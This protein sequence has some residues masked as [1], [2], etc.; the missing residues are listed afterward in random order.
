MLAWLVMTSH[1]ATFL[2]DGVVPLALGN[3]G[4]FSF[5]VLSGFVIAEA[6]DRFYPGAPQRFLANR[7]LRIYPT[8]WLACALALAIYVPLG[9]PDLKLDAATVLGNLSIVFPRPGMFSWL[10]LIWAVGIEL[11]FYFIA[12]LMSWAL[13][14]FKG[15]A[16]L[17][18]ALFGAGALALYC[19][20]VA[21]DF[22]R[23]A[24]FRFAPFFVLGVA[25]YYAIA[26]ASRAAALAAA[27]ALPFVFHSYYV[28]NMPGSAPGTT[29]VLFALTL[30]VMVPAAYARVSARTMRV[31]KVLGDLTY[32]LYLV[33]WPIVYLVERTLPGKGFA[34]Y[35]AVAALS[36][37]AAAAVLLAEQPITHLRDRVRRRRLYG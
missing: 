29:S 31:D 5:F 23:L 37:A 16:R 12:A 28:Y 22:T 19:F 10:S 30:A 32:P 35:C 8:F 2:P 14:A 26:Q 6:C 17:V 7:L 21:S 15:H 36:V 4:V 24:T 20:T 18:F 9:H 11:R 3:V 34:G 27:V 1:S 25:A 13:A 33:H